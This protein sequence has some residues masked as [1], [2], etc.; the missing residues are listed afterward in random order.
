MTGKDGS[1]VQCGEGCDGKGK[2]DRREVLTEMEY[3]SQVQ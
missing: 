1:Q 3:R 2:Y